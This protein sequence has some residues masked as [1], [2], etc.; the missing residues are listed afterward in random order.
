MSNPLGA[1][2]YRILKPQGMTRVRIVRV[3]GIVMQMVC[4]HVWQD[5]HRIPRTRVHGQQRK[6]K[7]VMAMALVAHHQQQSPKHATKRVH[8]AGFQIIT[9]QQRMVQRHTRRR[10]KPPMSRAHPISWTHK[11]T[12][13]YTNKI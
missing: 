12:S 8:T 5:Q 2:I 7:I 11:S 13:S 6:H 3:I 10:G 1:R 4:Q 9:V